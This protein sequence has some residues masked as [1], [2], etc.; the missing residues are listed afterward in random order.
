[1]GPCQ[2][3]GAVEQDVR[4]CEVTEPGPADPAI[5]SGRSWSRRHSQTS[6]GRG[7]RRILVLPSRLKSLECQLPTGRSRGRRL[8]CRPAS[9]RRRGSRPASPCRRNPR[10][11]SPGI[12]RGRRDRPRA[13][14]VGRGS[15]RSQRGRPDRNRSRS[16][17]RASAAL[18]AAGRPRSPG[19]LRPTQQPRRSPAIA[20]SRGSPFVESLFAR[21]EA[22]SP[23][24]KLAAV[25][26]HA[27]CTASTP[28]RNC[29]VESQL[30]S[31]RPA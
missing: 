6:G 14:T 9:W 28:R 13:P 18:S 25:P 16:R 7:R 30:P 27:Y 31:S 4:R 20:L 22:E 17:A 21:R 24:G 5:R 15:S 3:A 23:A 1:M 11:Q 2:T 29:S 26:V 8:P 19:R 12:C 10:R